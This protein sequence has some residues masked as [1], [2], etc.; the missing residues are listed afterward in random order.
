MFSIRA[1]ALVAAGVLAAPTARADDF[2]GPLGDGAVPIA[3]LMVPASQNGSSRTMISVSSADAAGSPSAWCTFRA[4][5]VPA[6]GTPGS[7]EIAAGAPGLFYKT[8][9]FV[10]QRALYCAPLPSQ[11]ANLTIEA[12]Q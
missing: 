9:G 2:S 12:L 8:P 10:P 11:V 1:A 3:H 6:P 5:I 7:F 4:S